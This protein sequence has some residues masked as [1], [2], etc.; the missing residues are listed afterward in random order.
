MAYSSK[1]SKSLTVRILLLCIS[2]VLLKSWPLVA[3]EEQT[4]PWLLDAVTGSHDWL[5]VESAPRFIALAQYP[6]TADPDYQTIVIPYLMSR[7]VSDSETMALLVRS[8]LYNLAQAL[9]LLFERDESVV[10]QSQLPSAL[11]AYFPGNHLQ[12]DH[13]GRELF[14][15]ITFYMKVLMTLADELQLR[16]IPKYQSANSTNEGNILFP[17]TA[18]VLEIQKYN[19]SLQ[20]VAIGRIYFEAQ[21]SSGS[22]ILD[23]CLELFQVARVDNSAA[24]PLENTLLRMANLYA[25]SNLA[26]FN[27]I[28]APGAAIPQRYPIGHIS[29]A[30]DDKATVYLVH[31]AIVN[32]SIAGVRAY[33]DEVGYNPADGS[34]NTKLV[35][36]ASEDYPIF[37]RIVE[38]VHYGPSER[39]AISG[40]AEEPPELSTKQSDK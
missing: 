16:H 7:G 30:T 17:S 31:E 34:T 35:S 25:D 15:P 24:Q 38:V 13:V 20:E 14:G 6:F 22:A 18:V 26:L 2:V 23:K 3:A 40:S 33:I 9:S 5:G 27:A 11:L 19:P 1:L 36:R 4:T 29:V 39:A 8:D 21:H 37:N 28:M 10:M 32:D 12:I